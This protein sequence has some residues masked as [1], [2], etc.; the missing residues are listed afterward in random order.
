MQILLPLTYAIFFIFFILKM[1]FFSIG[2]L[3]KLQLT[4][5]FVL[6]G[7]AGIIG[8]YIYTYYY[9]QSDSYLYLEGSKNIFDQFTGNTNS[10]S[11]VGWYSNFDDVFY[12]NSRII[13]SVNFLIQFF[14]F[15][16]PFV[17]ILFFCFF[18]FV[19]L[20]ALYNA[21]YKY[22]PEKKNILL[23]GIFIVP[24]ALFWTSGIYKEAIAMLCVGL[25]VYV[26]DFGL[27][28]S[29]S[30][31]GGLM[32]ALLLTLLFFLKIYI[33]ACLLPLLLINFCIT[34]MGNKNYVLKFIACFILLTGVFYLVSKISSKTN[35]Y[36][37][38]ADKQAKAISEASGGIFLANENNF[39]CVGYTD[40][41]SVIMKSDSSYI[42]KSGSKYL[43][44][45]LDN[46]KDTSFVTSS[47]DTSSF[48]LLYKIVPANSTLK[49][50]KM[51][52]SF[53]G[54]LKNIPMAIA[55]VFFQPTLFKI[56]NSLQL[57]SWLENI[58]L[59]LLLVLAILFF[60]KKM[61]EHKEVLVFCIVFALLQFALIG[62]VTPAIGAMVRYKVTAI[63]FLF[64]ICMLCIDGEKLLRKIKRTKN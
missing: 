21:F 48:K 47:V 40:S 1:K 9:P 14:S 61:L 29:Y 50:H 5:L 54:M 30:I 34:R 59:L 60:D 13:I 36:Q 2:T 51:N 32:L 18:S 12:N 44:W 49:M 16:N 7:I 10:T 56:K 57:F 52:P 42:I 25:I 33:L 24:S 11:V 23:I 39:I 46:M 28:K 41:A 3:S 15:N 37:L 26:S 6:K 22:F 63:L 35:F 38:I 31:K 64:T 19:G 43:L 8:F 53:L 4:G 62:L 58:W 45:K 55:N 20:T 17:H 27:A